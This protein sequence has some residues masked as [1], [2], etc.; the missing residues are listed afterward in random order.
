[1]LDCV[2]QFESQ[3]IGIAPF[4]L[5]P[6]A[7]LSVSRAPSFCLSLIH[8]NSPHVYHVSQ[9]MTALKHTAFE[10]HALLCEMKYLKHLYT[11]PRW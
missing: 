4:F 1:M 10:H 5:S 9:T 7:P 3:K 2:V 8:L 11:H 6:S